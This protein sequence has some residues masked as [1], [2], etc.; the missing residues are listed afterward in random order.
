LAGFG[1]TEIGALG[2][3]IVLRFCIDGNGSLGSVVVR[4]TLDPPSTRWK[5]GTRR[6]SFIGPDV[7]V[8]FCVVGVLVPP[9]VG[10]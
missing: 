3:E 4:R 10:G 5:G 2:V 8:G 6:L 7:V 9:P 1:E